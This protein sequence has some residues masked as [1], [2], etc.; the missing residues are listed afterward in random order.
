MTRKRN[1]GSRERS[2]SD[3]ANRW[4]RCVTR[5]ANHA[6]RKTRQPPPP[7][8]GPVSFCTF[9]LGVL[10]TCRPRWAD[11]FGGGASV[12]TRPDVDYEPGSVLVGGTKFSPRAFSLSLFLS[13]SLCFSRFPHSTSLSLLPFL[14]HCYSSHRRTEGTKLVS[15]SFFLSGASSSRSTHW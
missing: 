8:C 10:S 14:L 4:T 11:L 7:V 1:E 3:L 2:R 12:T 13:F 6:H 15:K 5:D 9:S